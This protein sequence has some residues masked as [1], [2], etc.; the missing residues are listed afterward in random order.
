M[1]LGRTRPNIPKN[2]SLKTIDD[3][4]YFRTPSSIPTDRDWMSTF[5]HCETEVSAR[6]LTKFCQENGNNWGPIKQEDLDKFDSNGEF[7]LN[8]LDDCKWVIIK[9]GVIFITEAFVDRCYHKVNKE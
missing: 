2:D 5:N 3:G 4:K 6:L 1:M 8:G 9:D 7:Y